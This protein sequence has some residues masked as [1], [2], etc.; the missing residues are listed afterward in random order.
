VVVVVSVTGVIEGGPG[1]VL[2]SGAVPGDHL[3]LTG[4]VGASAAGLRTLRA[5]AASS[6]RPESGGEALVEAFLR[7]RARLAEGEA[8][9]LGGA[10]AMIDVSDGLAADLG[11]LAEASGV[12]FRLEQVPVAPGATVEEALGGGEDY[13]LV[14]AAADVG[15]VTA[16]FAAAGLAPPLVIGTCTAEP[17]ERSWDGREVPK[18]G[19]E[20]GWA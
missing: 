10:T 12:G 13:E 9:R 4:P 20:H 17:S 16:A 2:R 11:H 18:V 14:F 19:W 5:R 15:R 7:P 6:R 1:P 8:A 3:L